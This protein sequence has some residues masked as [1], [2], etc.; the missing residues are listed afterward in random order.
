MYRKGKKEIKQI[1]IY[2]R[3]EAIFDGGSLR[4]DRSSLIRCNPD[5]ILSKTGCPLRFTT[6]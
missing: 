1:N 6:S 3:E 4:P 5:G 2:I